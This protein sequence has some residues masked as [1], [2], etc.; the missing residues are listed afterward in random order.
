MI[1]K[2]IQTQEGVLHLSM[3]HNLFDRS[4]VTY[5]TGNNQTINLVLD[6]IHHAMEP[7][8]TERLREL[9]LHSDQR[10]QYT[11][12]VYFDLTK[13]YDIV[14]FIP[15]HGNCYDNA[16]TENF[17]GILKAE[18]IYRHKLEAFEEVNKMID[19]HLLLQPRTHLTKNRTV[20]AFAS[21]V[22]LRLSPHM[23]G[24]LCLL[25]LGAVQTL[26]LFFCF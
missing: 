13:E 16:L 14:S 10:F 9:H 22:R 6:T 18:Y 3:I 23:R 24:Y 4:I 7:V 2:Y 25:I 26:Y 12:Q 1:Q 5:G 15:R 11:S 19:N 20:S 17:F 21:S 8:K